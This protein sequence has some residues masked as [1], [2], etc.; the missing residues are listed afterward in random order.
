MQAAVAA[1]TA[2]INPAA[3]RAPY[4]SE[5]RRSLVRCNS[6]QQEWPVDPFR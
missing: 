3:R 5:D 4:F 1:K 2:G 6:F